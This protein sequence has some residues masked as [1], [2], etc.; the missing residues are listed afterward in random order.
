MSKSQYTYWSHTHLTIEQLVP[1]RGAG[2][3][4]EAPYGFRWDCC[5]ERLA[6]PAAA[7]SSVGEVT[8]PQGAQC[9]SGNRA[10]RPSE[11]DLI[12]AV[13]RKSSCAVA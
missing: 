11:E 6:E 10:Q 12:W 4:L 5:I 9:V 7:N 1:G 13:N 2:F 8:T 3:S